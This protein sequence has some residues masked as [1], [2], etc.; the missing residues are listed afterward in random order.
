MNFWSYSFSY[1]FKGYQN[2]GE[3]YSAHI[4]ALCAMTLF[5]SCNALSILFFTISRDYLRTKAF[6][7]LAIIMFVILLTLNAFYFLKNKRYLKMAAQ[8]QKLG[9]ES[10]RKGK[11]RFWGYFV[12]TIV[13]LVSSML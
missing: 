12:I 8:Y 6:K 4:Y 9:T 5:L 1:I 7:E 3:K 11:L 10:K 2:W 13:L